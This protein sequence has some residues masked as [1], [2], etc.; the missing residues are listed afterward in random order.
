MLSP[1]LFLRPEG[2]RM[3]ALL[4]PLALWA[5]LAPAP[6][7]SLGCPTQT[8][9]VDTSVV[10]TTERTWLDEA[11]GETFVARDTFV[12]RVVLWQAAHTDTA[13]AVITVRFYRADS[14]GAVELPH[15]FYVGPTVAIPLGDTPTKFPVVFDLRPALRLP[16]LGH[17]EV[18]FKPNC[19]E[20]WMEVLVSTT[21]VFADG[22]WW[23]D[24][25][26]GCPEYGQSASVTGE[27]MLCEVDL[28]DHD[29]SVNT[30]AL[31][32]TWGR[33]KSIYH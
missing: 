24:E 29:P 30:A 3:A 27:D 20:P 17:F 13:P 28:C 11:F 18:A 2:I 7:V 14:T 22:N 5:L 10:T 15:P 21:D 6:Q 12:T 16:Y 31:P 32:S 9:A 33:V 4:A 26:S 23:A 25:W 1:A 19:T 8:V